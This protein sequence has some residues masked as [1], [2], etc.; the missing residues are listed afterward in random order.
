MIT[1]LRVI[2]GGSMAVAT[3]APD[4][5]PLDQLKNI[6]EELKLS[7]YKGIVVFD[8]F[9]RNGLSNNRFVSIYFDSFKFDRKS[10]RVLLDADESLIAEQ[11]IFFRNDP[12][13]L[14]GSVLSSFEVQKFITE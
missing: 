3:A 5:N 1:K 8:L 13:F 9:A 12:K 2:R 11:D 10:F 14:K 6:G 7:N 4:F